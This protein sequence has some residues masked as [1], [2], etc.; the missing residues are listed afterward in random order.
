MNLINVKNVTD[1]LR[2]RSRL[3]RRENPRLDQWIDAYLEG[4]LENGRPVNILTP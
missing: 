1:F 3:I 4:C 2:A